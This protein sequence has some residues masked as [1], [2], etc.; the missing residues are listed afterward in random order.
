MDA[1]EASVDGKL[2]SGSVP[3]SSVENS[4]LR[5]ANSRRSRAGPGEIPV[6]RTMSRSVPRERSHRAARLHGS[7]DESPSTPDSPPPPPPKWDEAEERKAL[8][9]FRRK[10]A[11]HQR[12]SL[13]RTADPLAVAAAL[14]EEALAP[15]PAT[16]SD[17][18][19]R[20][21]PPPRHRKTVSSDSAQ[22]DGG[23]APLKLMW[24]RR[25]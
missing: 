3:P 23:G 13:A 9:Q 14:S 2:Q 11:V 6:R 22:S 21:R 16:R 19:Q 12:N 5:S 4:D 20:E 7:E 25:K 8:T 24:A 1:S 18:D 15:A 10:I 17:I